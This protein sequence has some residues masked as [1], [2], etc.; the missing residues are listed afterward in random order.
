MKFFQENYIKNF[1]DFYS[2]EKNSNNYKLMQ[3]L[4]YDRNKFL[5][6]LK[7]IDDSLSLEGSKGYTLNLYG[8]MVNQNRGLANDAQYLFLI[9]TKIARNRVNSDANSIVDCICK[10]LDC[11]PT[12]IYIEELPNLRV[13][14]SDIPIEKI[15]K[16]DITPNQ[17]TQII[18]SLLPAGIVLDVSVYSG[19]F[20]FSNEEYEKTRDAGF[21][22]NEGDDY[23]GF[24][25][26]LSDEDDEKILP[27]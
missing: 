24:L 7:E 3:L 5:S 9:K 13:R 26:M 8:D 14:L 15:L 10:I 20:A 4:E 2:K 1:P 25:G 21:C 27:V 19:S 17:F 12:E 22:Q 23:G 11:K 16:A 18:K 6:V